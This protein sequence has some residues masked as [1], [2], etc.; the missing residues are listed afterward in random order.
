MFAVHGNGLADQPLDV[1]QLAALARHAK[2]DRVTVSACPSRA[3]DTMNVGFR[4]DGQFVIDH[5]RDAIHVEPAG[6]N[7]SRHEG[8]DAAVAE[9]FQRRRA[10]TLT[11]VAVNDGRVDACGQQLLGDLVCRSLSLHK[12]DRLVHCRLVEERDKQIIFPGAIDKHHLLLD[13]FHRRLLGRDGY[14]HG[15]HQHRAGQLDNFPR[16]GCRE[17]KRLALFRQ[18]GDHPPHVVD[19]AHV[20]HAIRLIEHEGFDRI[21][22]DNVLIHQIQQPARRGHEEVHALV[23]G[24]LLSVLPHAPKDDRVRKVQILAVGGDAVADLRGQL[25]G[26]RENEH[27]RLP[28]GRRQW[29][30][31]EILQQGQREGRR[32]ARAGLGAPEQVL[33]REQMRNA[34]RLHRRRT[35][36]T[37]FTHRALQLRNQ[38][39]EDVSIALQLLQRDGRNRGRGR[40]CRT[41]RVM[42]LMPVRR[43]RRALLGMLCW[44]VVRTVALGTVSVSSGTKPVS[45]TCRRRLIRMHYVCK[46]GASSMSLPAGIGGE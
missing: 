24:L 2:A 1:P 23:H 42:P 10:G 17:K 25:A 29:V 3:A 4:L 37:R 43:L 46:S 26:R 45:A 18:R 30:T 21:E 15:I 9:I 5:V 20:Q 38:R 12:D 36:V 44:A 33:A 14:A 28:D 8:A 40:G 31:V 27:P 6:G 41:V 32:L 11:L 16:N 35:G 19:E 34:L 39:A 22:A 13:A 7:V